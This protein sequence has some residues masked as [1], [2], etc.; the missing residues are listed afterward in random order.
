MDPTEGGGGGPNEGNKK[1]T[2]AEKDLAEGIAR[3][4]E[5]KDLVEKAKKTQQ[6]I[7]Q[8]KKAEQVIMS[9]MIAASQTQLE[10]DKMRR[11]DATKKLMEELAGLREITDEK[12]QQE[13]LEKRLSEIAGKRVELGEDFIDILK[14]DEKFTK[15]IAE[16]TEAAE[17]SEEKRKKT[18]ETTSQLHNKIAKKLGISTKYS[19]NMVVSL[20]KGN[21]NL[22]DMLGTVLSF[23]N[24]LNNVVGTAAKMALE[25]DDTAKALGKAT[26]MGNQFQG[27]I[28]AVHSNTIAMGASIQDAS[29]ATK[30]LIE[31]F[32]AFNPNADAANEHMATNIVL[33]EK[34]GVNGADA[35]KS[36]DFFT[37]SMGMSAKAATD[38]TRNIAMMGKNMGVTA[39]KMISDFQSVSGDIAMYGARMEGVFQNLAAQA[40]AT[41][42]SMSSLV[43]L[44]K[45]FDTFDKAAD[46][47]AKLNAVLGTSLS[48]IDMMNMSYDERI[49]Y[50][51]QELRSVGANMDSMDPYTKM[52]IA[53]SLGVKDVAEAQRLL[54]MSQKEM[55]QNRRLQEAANT[56]QEK[57]KELTTELVPVMQQMKIAFSQIAV[58]V[59]PVVELF[60]GLLTMI[61]DLNTA[62]GGALVPTLIGFVA[63]KKALA[64]ITALYTGWQQLSLI[65]TGETTLAK[66]AEQGV[67]ASAITTKYADA[68]ASQ[69]QAGSTTLL[70][71]A[72]RN[73]GRAMAK[74]A[75]LLMGVAL[76]FHYSQSPPLYLIAGVMAIGVFLLARSLNTMGPAAIKGAAVLM[77]VA[78]AMG[79]MFGSMT[80]L[81]QSIVLL[82]D[83]LVGSLFQIP[84][85]VVGIYSIAGAIAVLAATSIAALVPILAIFSTMSVMGAA[86]LG[87]TAMAGTAVLGGIGE[88]LMAMGTGMEKFSNGLTQVS[89]LATQMSAAVG[90]GFMAITSDGA[91]AS[92]VIGTGD[93]MKN[94]VDGKI[95]VDVN[96]P[97]IKMPETTVNVYIDGKKMEGIIKKVV[98]R[99]G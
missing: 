67:T 44:G 28:L 91:G 56:R 92:A 59:S 33:L 45:Q 48:T 10:I 60:I 88:S 87:V 78:L 97:E 81:I 42:M 72:T 68:V 62:L 61:T 69:A 16:L 96:I 85:V 79:I 22:S 57:L 64:G 95:T 83:T 25:I 54:N 66:M 15:K 31:N 12:E 36:M 71:I 80:M 73:A 86:L 38:M 37:R 19:D 52:Y 13:H 63:V 18:I 94:F 58:A 8:E 4:K 30:S 89:K 5:L 47:T 2:G 84:L 98:S 76:A 82:F 90:D 53:Q 51:Q 93:I 40:K 6:E 43:N 65:A 26:G 99:A 41:G 23:K 34:I 3:Q 39:S 9:D 75:L 7:L 17:K 24:V 55:D 70:G 74:F 1:L 21:V 29:N 35:A 27:Q 20:L 46:T 32:S 50:L 14:D 11:E 77:L 49:K